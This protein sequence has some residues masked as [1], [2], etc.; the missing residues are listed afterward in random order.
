MSPA[1]TEHENL[2]SKSVIAFLLNVAFQSHFRLKTSKK[3]ISKNFRF[4]FFIIRIYTHI[5]YK[6]LAL[7]SLPDYNRNIIPDYIRNII[8]C[9]FPNNTEQKKN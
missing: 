2:Y 9:C 7:N 8:G 4:L 3:N 6:K 1:S 5:F